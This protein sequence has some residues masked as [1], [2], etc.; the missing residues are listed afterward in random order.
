MIRNGKEIDGRG[1][2]GMLKKIGREPNLKMAPEAKF[3]QWSYVASSSYI[4]YSK[5]SGKNWG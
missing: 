3:R 1:H 2:F 5:K 4:G